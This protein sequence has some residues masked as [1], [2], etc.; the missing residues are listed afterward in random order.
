LD[1]SLNWIEAAL[2]GLVQGL[3]EFLPVSSS[4]HLALGQVLL[5]VEAA[6]LTFVVIVHFGTLL[7]VVTEF[8]HLLWR[9]FVGFL[10]GD[11]ESRRMVLYLIIGTLPAGLIGVLFEDTI[12]QL[13]DSPVY[14]CV[15][16]V[17]TGCALY[18]TRFCSSS[19]SDVRLHDA[20]IIGFAQA[21][22]ILPGI[23]RSGMTISAGLWKGL[24]GKE[25]AQFSF[26]LSLPIIAGA[27][28]LKVKGLV[29]AGGTTD[30]VLPLVVGALVAYLSG[31]LAIRWLMS[32]VARRGL[33]RFS[34]YCW[35]VGAAGFILFRG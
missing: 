22:A 34:Y 30:S 26:L 21:A 6:D 4:G 2:L 11:G 19:R 15:F 18:S 29:E 20:I 23:S 8:R 31:I 33:E 12:S 32:I 1:L 35:A 28:V 14:V 7:A 13:F 25:A 17:L 24:E 16:L 9:L 5:R 10:R 3:A 27:T